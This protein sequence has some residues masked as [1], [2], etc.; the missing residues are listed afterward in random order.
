MKNN[1]S[2]MPVFNEILTIKKGLTE[3]RFMYTTES[4]MQ[5]M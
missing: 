2:T 5:L 3:I 1:Q 4:Q